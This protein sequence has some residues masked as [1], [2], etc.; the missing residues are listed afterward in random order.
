MTS[1]QELKNK[2]A[3]LP[4]IDTEVQLPAAIRAA[5]ARSNTLHAQAYQQPEATTDVQQPTATPAATGTEGQPAPAQ[6]EAAATPAPGAEGTTTPPKAEDWEHRYNSMKGR[7]D[8]AEDTIRGLVQRINAL[9]ASQH[10]PQPVQ[11]PTPDLQFKPLITDKDK[12]DFGADFIDVAQRA[13]MDKVSPEIAALKAQLARLEGTVGTVA[14]Q[15]AQQ[16]QQTIFQTLDGKLANWRQINKDAKFLAWVALP[17]PLSGV[18]RRNMMMD[19]FNQGDAQRVLRFFNGFL[20]EEAATAPAT[21][22]PAPVTPQGNGKVPLE[23]FAAPGRATTAAATTA[24][25]EKETISRRQIANFYALVNKG[26][27]RG[28]EAEKDALERRIFAAEAE[29]RI[30]D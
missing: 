22:Q 30:T 16:T 9:E 6:P 21:T 29:G 2:S 28:N 5:A 14:N 13:A 3:K 10:A 27:Y 1:L 15:T 11:Q 25:A 4:P 19:A 23:N 12:D 7:Y 24:P 26:H 18:I 8:R 17:D 20:S